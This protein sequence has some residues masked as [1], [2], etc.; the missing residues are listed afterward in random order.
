MHLYIAYYILVTEPKPFV[1]KIT[2]RLP[3]TQYVFLAWYY[4]KAIHHQL[5][6]FKNISVGVLAE[7]YVEEQEN[8]DL[9]CT[10]YKQFKLIV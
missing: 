10:Q 5:K 4:R 6:N 8:V 3:V 9:L 7:H 2:K 1:R